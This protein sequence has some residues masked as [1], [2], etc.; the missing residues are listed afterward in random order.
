[1]DK[2]IVAIFDV[3]GVLTNGSYIYSKDG[4]MYKTFGADDSYALKMIKD[5]V[6]IEFV[7]SDERGFGISEARVKDMGF[8][9]SKVSYK[10]RME[11]INQHF[12]RDNWIRIYM[13][14]SFTDAAIFKN[15]DVGIC[16]QNGHEI[17]KSFATYVTKHSGGDRAVADAVFYIC[18]VMLKKDVKKMIGL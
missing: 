4:K 14:D 3:D 11:W 1:M 5:E 2:K 7:S 18:E 6:Q 15:V 12:H 13:G 16:P 9:L 17:A 10:E 8:N